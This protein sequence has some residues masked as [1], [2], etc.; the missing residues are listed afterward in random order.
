VSEAAKNVEDTDRLGRWTS[1]GSKRQAWVLWGTASAFVLLLLFCF[2]P[3][4]AVVMDEGRYLSATAHFL[5]GKAFDR[6][7]EAWFWKPSS[8]RV[9]VRTMFTAGPAF[10]ALLIPFVAAGW[11]SC[12]LLGTLV[13]VLGFGGMIY[14]LRRR[15]LSPLWALGYL[16]YPAAIL[17]SRMILVDVPSAAVIVLL[18]VVLHW[19]RPSYFAA[20]L[21]MGFALLLKLSNLPMVVT[22]AL[23]TFVQDVAARRTGS[24]EGA[25]RWHWRWLWM[26]LGMLPGLLLF[27][28]VNTVFFNGPLG[29]GYISVSMT[30]GFFRWQ[31]LMEHLPFYVACL[32]TLY[33]F[34]LASPAFLRGKYR[35]EMGL[36]CVAVLAFFSFYFYVD[37][38]NT[39]YEFMVRGLRFHLSVLPFYILGYAYMITW[40]MQRIKWR[41]LVSSGLATGVL[42]VGAGD[43]LISFQHGR[44]AAR[45][46]ER[47]TR[48][49]TLLPQSG[50]VVAILLA[51]KYL[52]AA[53]HPELQIFRLAPVGEM[54][55]LVRELPLP[56]LLILV[57]PAGIRTE[58]FRASSGE[59]REEALKVA[60]KFY[61]IRQCE[62]QVEG[63][64]CWE[65]VRRLAPSKPIWRPLPLD[66][67]QFGGGNVLPSPGLN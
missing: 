65:L 50:P 48:L 46:W 55:Y 59:D 20:G 11:H 38:G 60:R 44:Y 6:S 22:F 37:P 42:L 7:S 13:H 12:F 53:N 43:A 67:V 30:G 19:E 51:Q 49:G 62:R 52:N 27:A 58:A 26:G 15:G 24:G 28:A 35:W 47:Q 5:S 66:S 64:D 54:P 31:F 45:E 18:L 29:N 10:S 41:W 14:V 63:F 17:Y 40:F 34:M 21:V 16:L 3:K 2:Y 39:W 9:F 23:V 33:P 32:M 1:V 36:C 8:D 4:A 25:G 61:E 56:T 57:D